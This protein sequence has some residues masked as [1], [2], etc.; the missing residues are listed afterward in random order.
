M[1]PHA[2]LSPTDGR[3]FN[4][5]AAGHSMME[6]DRPQKPTA[7]DTEPAPK[8]PG[9]PVPKPHPKK[10]PPKGRKLEAVEGGTASGEST[11]FDAETGEGILEKALKS[12]CVKE[13]GP[14][15]V[16]TLQGI[17]ANKGR[18]LLDGGATHCLRFG[19]PSEFKTARP[20]P[21]QLASGSTE[22]LRMNS[23]GTLLSRD[24]N[25][26]PILPMGLLADELSCKI[27]WEGK[28]CSVW[29]PTLGNLDVV[30]DRGCPEVASEVCLT[31]IHELE[32]QRTDSMLRMARLEDNGDGMRVPLESK[33]P[34]EFLA[35]LREWVRKTYEHVP[36]RVQA[37]LVPQ[38]PCQAASSGLNRHMRRRLER[39][40]CMLH[41]FAGGQRWTHPCGMPSVSLDINKGQDLLDDRL[42]FWL[43]DLARRGKVTYILAGPPCKTFSRLRTRSIEDDGP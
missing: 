15:M 38:V 4:C 25:V 41:L 37:K 1:H 9:V 14:F 28:E 12:M 16:A 18:G 5:G 2:S 23:A 36:K 8:H 13:K 35:G 19:T 10:R 29:H 17:Q 22:E 34:S 39:G 31:L 43:L 11:A 3:C 26:Q 30:M 7:A 33:D 20:V 42:L 32:E 21:V 24:V 6:C 40:N 27:A